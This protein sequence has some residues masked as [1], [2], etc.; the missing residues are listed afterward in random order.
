MKVLIIG[1]GGREHAICQKVSES[2]LVEKVYVAPGNPGMTKVAELVPLE[3]SQHEQLIQF[4]KEQAIGLTIIGP[5]VPLLAGLADQFEAAGLAVFGPRQAAAEIEGSK[6]F[7]KELMKKYQIPTADYAVF[8]SIEKARSYIEEKGAPIVIKADG[9]AAGKGVTVALTKEEAL[10]SV[11]EMLV[12]EKFGAASAQ[13]VIEEFLAGEEFSLMALV[14]G[15]VVIPL[16]IAQDHKRAYDGDL[17]PNTGGMGAYSPVPQI[18]N[19]TV[20]LAVDSVLIPAAKAMVQ[21]GKSF[22]GV[23]YAGLIKTAEGPKVIEFNARFGDPETQVIL[24]RLASDLVEV[25]LE[26][27]AG[28]SPELSWD[29]EAMVGV[30]V[31][32]SGYPEEYERGA[33]LS[34]LADFSQDSF[35]FHAGTVQNE[36]G[37]FVT[38]GGR[39]LLVG[40]KGESLGEA[41]AKV[42]QELEKLTCAGVFYRKDIGA[43]AVQSAIR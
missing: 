8:T 21:E 1:R 27:L 24:P 23:L 41:Q 32:A 9:L 37:Q 5:E 36:E 31:A 42:Y 35:T 40:A 34:G 14:N 17:G 15:E 16:E 11:E 13:V 19:D 33:V 4:A 38:A 29:S 30:V 6:S 39:V 28:K 26:L 22:C 43:K 3:E 20:Q 12:E 10:K 18:G 25:I 7:A 2:A